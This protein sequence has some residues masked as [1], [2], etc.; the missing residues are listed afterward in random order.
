M[1]S[2]DGSRQ[3]ADVFLYDS[4]SVDERADVALADLPGL[5]LGP[6]RVWADLEHADVPVVVPEL[7]RL[8]NLNPIAEG[9][10]LER[11]HRPS[12]DEYDTFAHV[13]IEVV[14]VRHQLEFEKVD[15]LVGGNWLVTVQDRPGDCFGDVRRKLR[16]SAKFRSLAM[17]FLLHALCESAC[18]DYHRVLDRFGQRLEQLEMRLVNRPVPAMIHR[19]HAAKRDLRGVRRAVVPLRESIETLFYSNRRWTSERASA[20]SDLPLAL[21]E[22]HDELGGVLDVLDAYR[23]AMQNLTDLYLSSLSN[24][25]NEILRVLTVISTIF[26]PL[27]FVAGVYGMNFDRMPELHWRYGYPLVLAIMALVGLC[28][29]VYF[30]R[31]GWLRR[32]HMPRLPTITRS[33]GFDESEPRQAT[34]AE[35]A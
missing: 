23:D 6:R 8:L 31:K 20:P 7:A 26:I 34:R 14:H 24:R 15:I 3:V 22:I 33:T 28:M 4:E 27:S 30:W 18:R 17:P 2:R 10:L 25:V 13:I 12:V 19:I 9:V 5:L 16:T 21:R 35:D 11:D 1:T 32:S 29:L